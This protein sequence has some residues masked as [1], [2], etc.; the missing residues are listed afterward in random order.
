[1][2]VRETYLMR[3]NIENY[4]REKFKAMKQTDIWEE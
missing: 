4:D 3:D 2:N 1:M